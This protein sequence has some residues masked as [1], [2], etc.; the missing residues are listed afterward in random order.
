M[1]AGMSACQCTLEMLFRGR[2]WCNS[3]P[4]IY[5]TCNLP[6]EMR[7]RDAGGIPQHT[8][9]LYFVLTSL[10]SLKHE[11]LLSSEYAEP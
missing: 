6:A 5:G 2:V 4:G 3:P 8:L 1:F 9:L 11:I 7:R 10:I